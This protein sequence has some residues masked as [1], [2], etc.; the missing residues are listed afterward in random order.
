[1]ENNPS[2][3]D[4]ENNSN[5]VEVTLDPFDNKDRMR[6][7]ELVPRLITF[8]ST[9]NESGDSE[10]IADKS[11]NYNKRHQRYQDDF[12]ITYIYLT[13]IFQILVSETVLVLLKE[14]F[15]VIKFIKDEEKSGDLFAL[16]E[17]CAENAKDMLRKKIEV[18][19]VQ[20]LT[21]ETNKISLHFSKNSNI[22]PAI[23]WEEA[24]YLDSFSNMRKVYLRVDRESIH[25]LKKKSNGIFISAPIRML[26]FVYIYD[27]LPLV[28]THEKLCNLRLVFNCAENEIDL[29]LYFKKREELLSVIFTLRSIARDS[30]NEI[31]FLLNE[32]NN[33]REYFIVMP[34]TNTLD[35]YETT[36]IK[37]LS[38]VMEENHLYD[39]NL[40]QLLDETIMNWKFSN[41]NKVD[42]LMIKQI[43]SFLPLVY[44]YMITKIHED[45]GRCQ[46]IKFEVDSDLKRKIW[47]KAKK[48]SQV[49]GFR[50]FKTLYSKL[51]NLLGLLS[52]SKAYFRE[53]L[54]YD[55][56]VLILLESLNFDDTYISYQSSQILKSLISFKNKATSKFEKSNKERLLAPNLNLI[57]HIKKLLQRCDK[58]V[59]INPN[60]LRVLEINGAFMLLLIFLKD[61]KAGPSQNYSVNS[62]EKFIADAIFEDDKSLFHL[63]DKLSLKGL[64]S[65]SYSATL[66]MSRAV[67]YYQKNTEESERK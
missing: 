48:V 29:K 13:D 11:G 1:M 34:W 42:P 57:G 7:E 22:T 41:I 51:L 55:E 61:D 18:W 45:Q 17:I 15:E 58:K 67:D 44:Q 35:D 66:L 3:E 40:L 36:I 39:I 65:V 30:V 20:T 10:I 56:F 33:F 46:L 23:Y 24:F 8:K 9:F 49:E 21:D 25:I 38:L 50:Y 27:V 47:T 28:K 2:K 4:T 19:K 63:L 43:V 37:E 6:N 14:N 54:N 59:E 64:F 16:A 5:E 62:Y 60:D 31:R 53:L 12:C 32:F 26:K 52:N